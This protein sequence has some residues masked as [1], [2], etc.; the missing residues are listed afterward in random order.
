MNKYFLIQHFVLFLLLSVGITWSDQIHHY[1]VIAPS[2]E[3]CFGQLLCLTLSQFAANSHSYFGHNK[4]NTS[5]LFLPGN[6]T[7]DRELTLAGGDNFSMTNDSQFNKDI[8]VKCVTESGKLNISGITF[9]SIEGLHFIGCGGNIITKVDQLMIS[10]TIFQGIEGRGRALTLDDVS[11]ARIVR[12]SFLSNIHTFIDYFPYYIFPDSSHQVIKFVY[13]QQ[14]LH[15]ST[16]GALY[17]IFSNIAIDNSMFK[18]NGADVGGAVVAH[19]SKLHIVKST[20]IYNRAVFGGVMVT[21]ESNITIDNST[22]SENSAA[23]LG[24]V[25]VAYN[26]LFIISST[27]FV[28]INNPVPSTYQYGGVMFT[29]GESSFTVK[30]CTFTNSSA[31]F[32]GVVHALGHSSFTI[33]DSNYFYNRAGYGGVIY[34]NHELLFNITNSFFANNSGLIRGAGGVIGAFGRASFT[35]TSSAFV[36]NNAY[37]SGVID[38]NNVASFIISKLM[39]LSFPT[40]HTLVES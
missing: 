1:I 34:T 22:F 11:T 33:I 32:G 13:L 10:D 40:K 5:L 35:I 8:Y 6:H 9:A 24:G 26:D 12:S 20:Y 30:N 29:V 27:N 38:I 7:L 36:N 19:N 25:T 31:Y 2:D 3:E 15:K 14:N 39:V 16:G 18:H 4:T 17:T 21:S 28:N 37:R 23:R